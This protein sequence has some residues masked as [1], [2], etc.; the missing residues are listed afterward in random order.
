MIVLIAAVAAVTPIADLAGGDPARF[1]ACVDL[2]RSDPNAAI[3]QADRWRQQS[4][5]V[6]AVQCLG[7]AYVAAQRWMPASSAFEQ[8]ARQAEFDGDGRAATLWVQAGNAALAANDPAKAREQLGRALALP[9]LLGPMRGEAFLDRARADAAIP[10]LP[11]ARTDLDEA[12]KFVPNDPLL[13]LLSATLARRQQDMPR[14]EAEIGRA[15]KLSPDDGAVAYEAG[16]VAATL[17]RSDAARIAWQ[18]AV[19]LDKDGSA[20]RAAA[21]M[22]AQLAAV[23]ASGPAS[24]TPKLPY[25]A[26]DGD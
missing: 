18:Q 22:L 8:A 26:L 13:W 12:A 5:T 24:S 14:A 3:E 2:V 17:G 21:Q 11:A 7:L 23:P 16:N 20:G 15:M 10:D 6:V 4:R 9:V 25:D 19:R 1:K